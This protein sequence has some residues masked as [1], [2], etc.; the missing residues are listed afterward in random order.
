MECWKDERFEKLLTSSIV[1]KSK[2]MLS[3]L[4]II[5]QIAENYN[6]DQ[7]LNTSFLLFSPAHN[8]ALIQYLNENYIPLIIEERPNPIFGKQPIILRKKYGIDIN[9]LIIKYPLKI[10]DIGK[11]KQKCLRQIR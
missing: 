6:I 7:Y 1:A 11:G 3:K 4:L 2:S 5:I 8:Y 9:K 10:K